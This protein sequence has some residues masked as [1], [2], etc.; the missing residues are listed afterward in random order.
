FYDTG[1]AAYLLGVSA[2]DDLVAHFARGHLFENLIVAE[3]T[4]QQ[5]V[6]GWSSDLYYWQE[7]NKHE[8]DLLAE[9]SNQLT[10]AEIKSGSTLNSS[11]FDNL[12]YFQKHSGLP[13]AASYLI[14]GGTERQS[15][16]A[17]EVRGWRDLEGMFGSL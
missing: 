10:V 5:Y 4:K 6:S 8:I 16:S 14:Y 13:L 9:R 7:S 1:L 12:L 3:I 15:R 2:A 11:F 17:G